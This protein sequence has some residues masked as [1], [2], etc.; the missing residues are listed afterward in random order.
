MCRGTFKKEAKNLCVLKLYRNLKKYLRGRKFRANRLLCRSIC[1]LSELFLITA[2]QCYEVPS[3]IV[4]KG[5]NQYT[6]LWEVSSSHRHGMGYH[7][8]SRFHYLRISSAFY[9]WWTWVRLAMK[10]RRG[11]H[12]VSRSICRKA[13]ANKQESESGS[14][15]RLQDGYSEYST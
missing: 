4:K 2:Y 6:A 11:M 15:L 8:V 10:K 14:F 12:L 7:Q 1:S 9:S 13:M 3:V 5:E